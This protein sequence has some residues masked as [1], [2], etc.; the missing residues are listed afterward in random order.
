M[1]LAQPGVAAPLIGPCSSRCL[2]CVLVNRRVEQ[3]LAHPSA[4]LLAAQ[5]LHVV[6]WPSLE[7]SAWGRATL[8]VIGM[9]AVA[10]AVMAVRRTPGVSRVMLYLGA[11]AMVFTLWEALDPD[12][13][14]VVLTS[15][16]LHA[17]FYLYVSYAMLRYLFHDDEVTSDE[18]YATAAA[19]T[20]VAWAFAYA[21]S[22][23]QVAPAG[24][25][26][27]PLRLR[28]ELV[29]A[30]LPVLLHAHQRR[31]VRHRRRR[32]AGAVPRDAGDDGR[33]VL[34][35]HGGLPDGRADHDAAPLSPQRSQPSGRSFFG[36]LET[37]SR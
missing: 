13:D 4:L 20:V 30:A 9:V 18:Y 29:R 33:R 2:D 16:L 31:P 27:Q 28:P 34:H 17:P 19:F 22:A 25:V 11:P 24:L 3:W 26:L 35:R 5:L 37:T 6:A 1:N 32:P 36:S 8:G 12:R 23:L 21:F 7:D 15:G 10:A 14:W